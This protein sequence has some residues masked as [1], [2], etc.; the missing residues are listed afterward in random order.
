AH[1]APSVSARPLRARLSRPYPDAMFTGLVQA[2]GTVAAAV[3]TP[4]GLDLTIDAPRWAHSPEHG[5]SI[6]VNGVCLTH[7]GRSGRPLT[8]RAVAE[9][10]SRSTLG[11]LRAADRV[12]L[13]HAVRADTLMGGHFVQGHIDAL[14]RVR[15][16]NADPADWRVEFD[17]AP[18]LLELLIPKGSVCIDGVSLTVARVGPDSFGVALIPTTLELT[19]LGALRPGSRV[20]IETDM[21]VR[22]VVNVLSLRAGRG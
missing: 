17:A 22:S 20:N 6:S 19:T 15:S 1:P 13:E 2:V 3:A 5:A 14:T 9:T 4:D 11:D 12:N 21:I 7:T 8:F 10:L 18:P 16:V